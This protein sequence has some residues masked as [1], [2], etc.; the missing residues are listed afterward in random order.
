MST[1]YEQLGGAPTVF[2]AVERF[3][4]KVVA[5]E[6]VSHFL[7][8]STCGASSALGARVAAVAESVR[9]DVLGRD[10]QAA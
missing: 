2:A 3:Y 7:L 6:R 9:H 1:L 5:G 8:A 4:R 10:A